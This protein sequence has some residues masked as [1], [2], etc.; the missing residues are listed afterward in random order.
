LAQSQAHVRAQLQHETTLRES[1]RKAAEVNE[2]SLRQRRTALQNELL[3][4]GEQLAIVQRRRDLSVAQVRR[5]EQLL[6]NQQSSVRQHENALDALYSFEQSIKGLN[7]QKDSRLGVLLAVE[8]ELAQAPLLLQQQLANSANKISQLQRTLAE[9]E[10]TAVSSL[11]APVD[12][13]VNNVLSRRGAAI[14]SRTPFASIVPLDTEFEALLFV[15]SRALG[16]VEK[17]QSVFL[18]Y[19]SYPARTHGYSS[20]RITEISQ[21]LLD[22]REHFFPIEMQ[23]PFYLV[24]AAPQWES[25]PEGSEPNLRSGMRFTAHLVV[26]EQTL[27][28]KLLAPL[29][30]LRARV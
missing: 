22:P 27:I 21:A 26:G 23:E 10:A 1:L 7:V 14:D 15:P 4:M 28:E 5:Q 16:E 13:I 11:T 19:D 30:T 18:D 8:Q 6:R 29:K 3:N 25:W 9:L 20:A 12:G 24:K 2:K 17:Q